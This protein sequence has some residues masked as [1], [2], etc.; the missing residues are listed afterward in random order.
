MEIKLNKKG[1]GEISFS[2]KEIWILI[3]NKKFIINEDFIDAFT[4]T[5]IQ[6]KIQL[7]EKR[8]KEQQE[9]QKKDVE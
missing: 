8:K 1:D 3:K 4:S 5:L 9:K 6:L 2:W 7:V